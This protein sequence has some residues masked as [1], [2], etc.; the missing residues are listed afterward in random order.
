MQGPLRDTQIFRDGHSRQSRFGVAQPDR[1]ADLVQKLRGI[2]LLG[3]RGR[4]LAAGPKRQ[5]RAELVGEDPRR[6]RQVDG[7]FRR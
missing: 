3:G 4:N 5:Q 6:Q 7:E 2:A 1:T